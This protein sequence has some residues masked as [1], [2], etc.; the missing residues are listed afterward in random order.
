MSRAVTA[1]ALVIVLWAPVAIA[2]ELEPR[3][4]WVAPVNFNAVIVGYTYSSGDFVVDPSLPAPDVEA[5][6]QSL[7]FSYYRTL[8]FFGRSSNVIATL[9]F[10]W[11]HFEGAESGTATVRDISGL[12]DASVRLAVNLVG[13]PTMTLPEFEAFRRAPK[14]IIG[15]GIRVQMPTGQYDSERLVNLGTNRWAFK[16]RVGLIIPTPRRWQFE[17]D[18]GMW[19]YTDNDNVMGEVLEQSP[20]GTIE[21]HIVYRVRPGFWASFDITH[22]EGGELHL[23]DAVSRSFSNTRLGGTLALPISGPHVLKFVGNVGVG[24]VRGNDFDTFSVAY[25]YGWLSSGAQ[26]I[27]QDRESISGE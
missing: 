7:P 21:G 16:P 20:L 3:A 13:G 27:R 19:F 6:T 5:R 9:P 18:L 4:Y 12:A 1:A 11:T 25:N 22:W 8:D 23:D 10:A 2:Q 15:A 26:A 17:F 14:P 24:T